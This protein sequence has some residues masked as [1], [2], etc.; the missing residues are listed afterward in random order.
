MESIISVKNLQ[1]AFG[2]QQVLKDV[3]FEV[4]KGTVFA[5]LGANGAG[6]TTTVHILS[7]LLSPDGGTAHIGGHE[8]VGDAQAVRSM[9]SVTGQYAAVD[10]LLTGREN[11]KMMGRFSHLPS[12][13]IDSKSAELLAML[14]LKSVADRRAGT[15]SGG[16]RRRL[17]LAISLL[18]AP[19]VI[20]LDEPTTGLDPRS[21][22]AIWNIISELVAGGTTI[23]L[24]T[25]YLEE[26][27]Q[28]ADMIAVLSDG[29]IVAAGTAEELK[30][31]IGDEV[32]H[33]SFE[34][35]SDLNTARAILG[36]AVIQEDTAAKSLILSS[37]GSTRTLRDILNSLSMKHVEPTQLQLRKP[38]LDDVF[39]NLTEKETKE[40]NH[41]K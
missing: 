4:K 10:E 13:V 18:A 1:K 39:L 16:T 11:M 29:K 14:D 5:L 40:H 7:T 34:D 2:K 12:K 24:T 32:V 22:Q 3:S 19:P 26:A 25:Q 33:L 27:D 23:F 36:E 37:D 6:K 20:F 9:I 30:K 38:T 21:R 35:D 41:A 31:Q 8:V 17:D 28:L 15:Y